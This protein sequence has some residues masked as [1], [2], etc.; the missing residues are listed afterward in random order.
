MKVVDV[1]IVIHLFI[2]GTHSIDSRQL[3]QDDSNWILPNIWIHEM[4]N[5]LSTFVK[6][7]GMPL[8]DAV[9]IL[10]LSWRVFGKST[11]K[12]KMDD[13]LIN[14]VQFKISG[15]DAEYIT[16]AQYQDLPLITLDKKLCNLL[17]KWTE[18]LQ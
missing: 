16:L 12:I 4:N 5:V 3:F 9:G 10:K 13:A 1:N 17:P 7:G 6:Q 15:Y 8:T 11:V 14:S 18:L 2:D